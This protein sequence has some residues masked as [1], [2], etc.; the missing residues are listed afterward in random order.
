MIKLIKLAE[1]MRL[2]FLFGCSALRLPPGVD[3]FAFL[4]PPLDFPVVFGLSLLPK[5]I[6]LV[7]TEKSN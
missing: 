2:T 4:A 7:P 1:L 6:Y 3:G 5:K